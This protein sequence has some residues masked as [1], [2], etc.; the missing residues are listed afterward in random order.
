MDIG[1]RNIDQLRQIG[2]DEQ[3]AS[4]AVE[5]IAAREKA[6]AE[7]RQIRDTAIKNM[8]EKYGATEAARRAGVSVSTVKAIRR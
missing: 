4:A 1:A 7:A 8:A 2:D 3:R 5:Y 6:I